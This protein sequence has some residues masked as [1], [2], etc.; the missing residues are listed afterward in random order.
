MDTE[1]GSYRFAGLIHDTPDGV[2]AAPLAHFG[3]VMVYLKALP[4]TSQ[5]TIVEL[6][7]PLAGSKRSSRRTASAESAR[8]RA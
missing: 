6:S 2:A 8:A 7:G 5:W 4:K 1:A 3:R